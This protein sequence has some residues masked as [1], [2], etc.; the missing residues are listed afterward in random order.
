MSAQVHINDGDFVVIVSRYGRT[1]VRQAIKVSPA[2]LF[3]RE[4]QWTFNGPDKMVEHRMRRDDVVFSSSSSAVAERL[5]AQ[6]TSSRAQSDE[7]ERKA[8]TRRHERDRKFIEQAN[9]E[10]DHER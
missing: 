3:Y 2:F 8:V 10:S 9:A 6:L 5:A 1:E 4:K 7:D